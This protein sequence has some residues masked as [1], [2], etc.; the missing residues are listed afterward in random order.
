MLN[1]DCEA[2]T[3]AGGLHRH[4][5]TDV[6]RV[7]SRLLVASWQE[8]NRE[9]SRSPREPSHDSVEA[10]AQPLPEPLIR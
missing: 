3:L 6:S 8:T 9:S 4:D 7:S 1:T 2:S 10:R 5:D